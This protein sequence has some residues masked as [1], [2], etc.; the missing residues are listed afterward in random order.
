MAVRGCDHD[1]VYSGQSNL[2]CKYAWI[3]LSCGEHGWSEDYVL[4][5]VN[6]D[7]Y[8]QLRVLHGWGA[9]TKL[10]APPRVPTIPAPKLPWWPFAPGA[11][12]F[13][14]LAVVCL[15]A[16]IPWGALGPILPLWAAL[17]GAGL[18]LG[19]ATVLFVCWRQGVR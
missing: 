1:R 5:Q 6:I 3:C 8:H 12:F 10:P 13:A 15:L 2:S 11:M 17:L 4:S 14:M 19:T 9:P 7:Q 18:G 16:A